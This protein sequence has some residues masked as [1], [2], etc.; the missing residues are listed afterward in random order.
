MPDENPET[1]PQE[2]ATPAPLVVP[3]SVPATPAPPSPLPP[4]TS[5]GLLPS[6]IH[7]TTLEEIDR[8]F[9]STN[10]RRAALWTKFMQWL[11]L[12]RQE[13]VVISIFL[14]GS[15]TTVKPQ[16]GDIDLVIELPDAATLRASG[17]LRPS[18]FAIINRQAVKTN[19]ELDVLLWTP[20]A[21]PKTDRDLVDF[22][23]RVRPNV[24][25]ELGVDPDFRK[26]I[27]RV[28]L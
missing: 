20:D 2:S 18:F 8:V 16:P 21:P 22:F 19:Y 9:G 14:D 17:G 26:G 3:S 13:N 6:G 10:S 5:L 15:F 24:A 27:I 25:A 12:M 23:Q 4:L 11:A 28:M 7:T 1:Y